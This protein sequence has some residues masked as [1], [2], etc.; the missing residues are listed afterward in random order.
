MILLAGCTLEINHVV[1][2]RANKP[3]ECVCVLLE[4]LHEL[5]STQLG[6]SCG[7]V[8]ATIDP[9]EPDTLAIHH[10]SEQLA[11]ARLSIV[12][13]IHEVD[14]FQIGPERVVDQSQ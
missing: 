12:P 5:V 3:P 6:K 14:P 9:V 1:E 11:G 4:A 8:R 10:M 13:R 7:C 2:P